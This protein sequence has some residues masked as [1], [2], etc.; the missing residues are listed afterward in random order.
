MFD[1]D[2][3]LLGTAQEKGMYAIKSN[4]CIA[5][6]DGTNTIVIHTHNALNDTQMKELFFL[7]N[8]MSKTGLT[9]KDIFEKQ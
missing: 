4:D 5:T 9:L 6:R 8:G 7:A 2:K 3:A 1:L